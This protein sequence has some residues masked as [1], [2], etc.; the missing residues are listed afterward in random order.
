MYFGKKTTKKDSVPGFH[1]DRSRLQRITA[2]HGE[3]SLRR[4]RPAPSQ[5]SRFASGRLLPGP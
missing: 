1:I 3:R 2:A 5:R 4:S